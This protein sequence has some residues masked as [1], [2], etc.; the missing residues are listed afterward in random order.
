MNRRSRLAIRLLAI[1]AVVTIVTAFTAVGGTI[2]YVSKNPDL[3]IHLLSERIGT[4]IFVKEVEIGWTGLGPKL[5]MHDVV[6]NDFNTDANSISL[7]INAFNLVTNKPDV[8]DQIEISGATIRLDHINANQNSP[9][10]NTAVLH[11]EIL[12][13]LEK[14]GYLRSLTLDAVTII[15]PESVIPKSVHISTLDV[16]VSNDDIGLVGSFLLD[17]T[18]QP[19][20]I[21]GSIMRPIA[22]EMK[23][24]PHTF[25]GRLSG[26]HATLPLSFLPSAIVTDSFDLTFEY[27]LAVDRMKFR[28]DEY[29]IRMPGI[30]L[31]G[32]LSATFF[33]GKND[34]SISAIATVTESDP[35]KILALIPTS[36]LE[37]DIV[38]W[39]KDH[40]HKATIT[41]GTVRVFYPE[42]ASSNPADIDALSI[43]LSVRGVQASLDTT[44]P[45]VS[46]ASALLKISKNSLSVHGTAGRVGRV[47]VKGTKVNIPSFIA[48]PEVKISVPVES[49]ITDLRSLID[50]TP[51]RTYLDGFN[52]VTA[53]GQVSGN[54]DLV[55]GLGNNTLNALN[56]K[57]LLSNGEVLHPA[58][59]FTIRDVNSTI[60]FDKNIFTMSAS[61][62]LINGEDAKFQ[63]APLD[64]GDYQLTGATP[65]LKA[66]VQYFSSE[67]DRYMQF[68]GYIVDETHP[69]IS[70]KMLPGH[71]LID[72]PQITGKARYFQENQSWQI[73]ADQINVTT[74]TT[75][76][77]ST[78]TDPTPTDFPAFHF[79]CADLQVN[80]LHFGE[81]EIDAEKIP[82]GLSFRQLDLNMGVM[83]LYNG[84]GTWTKNV[85]GIQ[86]TAVSG[87][88]NLR[89]GG[90]LLKILSVYQ[91]L[92]RAHGT[93]EINA[94]WNGAPHKIAEKNLKATASYAFKDGTLKKTRT[95]ILRFVDLLTLNAIN[96]SGDDLPV[97]TFAG[98]ATYD[99]GILQTS[100]TH[101]ELRSA[102]LNLRGT[103]NT[104]TKAIDSDVKMELKITRLISTVGL[105]VANPFLGLGYLGYEKSASENFSFFDRYTTQ[106]YKLVGTWLDPC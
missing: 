104:L 16:S 27:S 10:V 68:G 18:S 36:V 48:N 76:A 28:S 102:R 1:T 75:A 24:L 70:D 13:Y 45:A 7:R 2:F 60:T 88:V 80:G 91:D 81:V 93:I 92:E 43:E 105:A 96:A 38:G 85:A 89:D 53:T 3:V 26:E 19:F 44:L 47:L 51:L 74:P 25:S 62:A 55:F 106:S 73:D 54:I 66:V 11:Q 15:L 86:E 52:T 41:A 12:I 39:I 14:A 4:P 97:E 37:P 61:K 5:T 22:E 57:L 59:P 67:T 95:D 40:I 84:T 42:I 83:S 31:K 77:E 32:N 65:T 63:V 46:D 8:F 64:N 82:T 101:I 72:V 103:T 49:N 30:D 6:I 17:E 69:E 29:T 71:V 34:P 98:N 50:T 20:R 78:R 56:G 79:K 23:E 100:D 90:R 99:N 35:F 58:L 21:N 94:N 33:D 87:T 9:A